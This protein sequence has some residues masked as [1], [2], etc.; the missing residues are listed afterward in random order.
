M[1]FEKPDPN[2]SKVQNS[3]ILKDPEKKLSHLDQ[4]Q[5][6]ELKSLILE[7]EHLFPDIPTRT[8]KIYHDVDIEGS[9]PIKQQPYRVSPMKLQFLREKIHYLWFNSR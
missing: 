3:D 4:T 8:D 5:R 1:N 7:Y 2:C 6:D 9:K